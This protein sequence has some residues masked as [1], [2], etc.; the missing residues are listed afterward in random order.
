MWRAGKGGLENAS[1]VESGLQLMDGDIANMTS[2]ELREYI[3][4]LGN[5]EGGPSTQEI[6]DFSGKFKKLTEK[7]GNIKGGLYALMEDPATFTQ[8][9]T[10]S[11]AMMIATPFLSEETARDVITMGGTGVAAGAGITAATGG[12]AFL[13]V[14]T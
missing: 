2:N 5:A 10:Q 4:N 3:N 14:P 9:F 6:A 7:H 11:M 1:T 8:F 12:V 13:S